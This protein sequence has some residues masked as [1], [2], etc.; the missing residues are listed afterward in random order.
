MG[1]VE[2]FQPFLHPLSMQNLCS[3][4]IMALKNQTNKIVSIE[5][6]VVRSVHPP[7]CIAREVR[8][9][10]FTALLAITTVTGAYVSG[11]HVG[12]SLV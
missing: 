8:T 5:S 10:P 3:K 11:D 4:Q 12:D 9:V 1:K 2:I 7:F 6:K